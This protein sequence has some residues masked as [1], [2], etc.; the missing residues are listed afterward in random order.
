M[1]DT[2]RIRDQSDQERVGRVLADGGQ[3]DP[4]FFGA[5][6]TEP[7]NT[8]RD[9]RIANLGRQDEFRT[10]ARLHP[11]S[12]PVYLLSLLSNGQMARV[13]NF[14]YRIVGLWMAVCQ[15]CQTVEEDCVNSDIGLLMAGS[16][17][18]YLANFFN[19][20]L[21]LPSS[22]SKNDSVMC[23]EDNQATLGNARAA[24]VRVFR[25]VNEGRG[26]N[27]RRRPSREQ[28][29]QNMQL[30]G[31]VL[32]KGRAGFDETE[33]DMQADVGRGMDKTDT[34]E[35]RIHTTA[36]WWGQQ[37]TE[38]RNEIV[39]RLGLN[40][41]GLMEYIAAVQAAYPATEGGEGR[42]STGRNSFDYIAWFIIICRWAVEEG[43]KVRR[44]IDSARKMKGYGQDKTQTYF[45]DRYPT[46]AD[47]FNIRNINVTTTQVDK[48]PWMVMSWNRLVDTLLIGDVIKTGVA[49][50]TSQLGLGTPNVQLMCDT[51]TE[52]ENIGMSMNGEN[53]ALLT[54]ARIF[55]KLRFDVA[56]IDSVHLISPRAALPPDV[57]LRIGNSRQYPD[58]RSDAIAQG[59]NVLKGDGD[60]LCDRVRNLA[61]QEWY[62]STTAEELT[63]KIL[64]S[65]FRN[66]ADARAA[67]TRMNFTN[68][69]TYID[70]ASGG[71][72]GAGGGG[73][74]GN[75]GG[76]RGG[77]RG[78]GGRGG[79]TNF[80]GPSRDGTTTETFNRPSELSQKVNQ[81]ALVNADTRRRLG[82]DKEVMHSS[83]EKLD[84][85]LKGGIGD[86]FFRG[87]TVNGNPVT[88][89][90]AAPIVAEAIGFPA[91][92][93]REFKTLQ[94]LREAVRKAE[95]SR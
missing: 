4:L 77:G 44:L 52:S 43:H 62:E 8:P 88:E 49:Q 16:L 20:R 48:V 82:T 24:Y 65:I 72:G 58:G 94:Q 71:G 41:V 39:D 91:N 56:G 92:K 51:F 5:T 85:V 28:M 47:A 25:M 68:C 6:I 84:N 78:G 50:T 33:A 46:L 64:T 45:R 76:G 75:G 19:N 1:T 57:N 70:A 74:N 93:A 14:P 40:R 53:S 95:Y 32:E 63:G 42:K 17:R 73:R 35:W 66:A 21:W 55:D 38:V 59:H 60:L 23:A 34:T 10:F 36:L 9:G 11:L 69:V 27:D 86:D 61:G 87:T 2:T 18:A 3:C 81:A 13:L 79:G 29:E 31:D 80:G 15:A 7:A 67:M 37:T 22:S 30:Y 83:I 89:A 90:T 26:G 54:V 12:I